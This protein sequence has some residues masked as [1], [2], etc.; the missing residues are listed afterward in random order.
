MGLVGE[1]PED[2]ESFFFRKATELFECSRKDRPG[3][4][5]QELFKLA[6]EANSCIGASVLL[7]L[8]R[9]SEGLKFL[10]LIESKIPKERLWLPYDTAWL[11]HDRMASVIQEQIDEDEQL[12]KMLQ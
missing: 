11:Y 10:E 4:V 7:D 5:V 2:G 8:F 9:I 12:L 3:F 1:L 6:P